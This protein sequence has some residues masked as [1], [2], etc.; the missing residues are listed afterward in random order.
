MSRWYDKRPQLGKGLDQFKEMDP[1]VREP[2]LKAIIHL[3]EQEEPS[4]LSDE[5]A[6]EFRLD[7]ARLRWYEHDP[8]CWL[9]FNILEFA[10]I[11]IWESVEDFLEARLSLAA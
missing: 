10:S 11:A 8:Y 4:L 7:S 6:N 5:K 3:V 1:Q 2:I 9:V